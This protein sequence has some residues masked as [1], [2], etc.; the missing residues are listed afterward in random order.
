[1]SICKTKTSQ[2]NDLLY[3]LRPDLD[4]E[5]FIEFRGRAG[6]FIAYAE[7]RFF[8]DNGDYLGATAAEAK[9]NLKA[10]I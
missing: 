7:C 1:M 6:W 10:M 8:G 9:I 2:L 3:D 4:S 5:A